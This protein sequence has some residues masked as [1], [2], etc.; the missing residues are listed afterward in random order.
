ME[1]QT[2]TTTAPAENGKYKVEQALFECERRFQALRAIAFLLEQCEGEGPSEW[3]G[4]PMQDLEELLSLLA[5][6]GNKISVEGLEIAQGLHV[7]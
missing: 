7:A 5:E 4:Q 2:T 1:T 6:D 3:S